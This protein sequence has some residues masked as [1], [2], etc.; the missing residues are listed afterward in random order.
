MKE[1]TTR[2]QKSIELTFDILGGV[3]KDNVLTTL[4]EKLHLYKK[5]DCGSFRGILLEAT[6]RAGCW[7]IQDY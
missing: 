1:I 5:Y 3:F 4:L 7:Y 6:L 2:D